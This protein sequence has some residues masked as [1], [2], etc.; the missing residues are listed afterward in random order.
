ME[1]AKRSGMASSKC[2]GSCGWTGKTDDDAT[3]ADIVY[4]YM[5]FKAGAA[6]GNQAG[7]GGARRATMGRVS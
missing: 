5:E 4:L 3:E 1:I 6:G 7:S 2:V